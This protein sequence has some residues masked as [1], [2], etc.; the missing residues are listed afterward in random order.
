MVQL[1]LEVD[2]DFVDPSCAY[3]E[4]T[5]HCIPLEHEIDIEIYLQGFE[6]LGTSQ[7]IFLEHYLG[8]KPHRAHWNLIEL[9]G[10]CIMK[11]QCW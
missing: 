4:S 2:Q 5:K 3:Q 7:C 6:I 8:N 11:L 9:Y 10:Q 1:E